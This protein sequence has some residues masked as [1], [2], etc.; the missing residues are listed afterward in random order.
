MLK[1]ITLKEDVSAI[2]HHQKPKL[3]R[4]QPLLHQPVVNN[5]LTLLIQFAA[6]RYEGLAHAFDELIG[7]D[8][9]HVIIAVENALILATDE[10]YQFRASFSVVTGETVQQES[11]CHS[12]TV[13]FRECDQRIRP[14]GAS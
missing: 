4:R 14:S 5:F 6:T 9:D 11:D 10:E 8:R 7:V 2:D 13:A 12:L 1:G 3:I